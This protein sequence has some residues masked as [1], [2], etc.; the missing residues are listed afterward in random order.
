MSMSGEGKLEETPWL[1][2][3]TGYWIEQVMQF[4]SI[5]S[6]LADVY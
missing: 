6:R 2:L 5:F 1:E 4:R 3:G